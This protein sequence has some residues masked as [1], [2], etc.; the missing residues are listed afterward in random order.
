MPASRGV[1]RITSKLEVL[2]PTPRSNAEI[3]LEILPD[4]KAVSRSENWPDAKEE[5]DEESIE[6]LSRESPE[7]FPFDPLNDALPVSQRK[8]SETTKP[9]AKPPAPFVPTGL[10]PFHQRI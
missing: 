9:D 4:W 7:E 10:F 1:V 2:M 8:D 5:E 3:F 6:L